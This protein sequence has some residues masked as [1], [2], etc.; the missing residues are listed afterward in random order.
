MPEPD[1][2]RRL[3]RRA[4]V[5]GALAFAAGCSQTKGHAAGGPSSSTTAP[6]LVLPGGDSGPSASASAPATPIASVG[7]V[8][9][10]IT[11]RSKP[12]LTSLF[13]AKG[14]AD[15]VIDA[16]VSRRIE[17]GNGKGDAPLNGETALRK[18]LADGVKPDVWVFA[19]GTNDVG[20]VD[21][22]AYSALIETMLAMPPP[23]TPVV[24]VDVY[25]PSNL[26]QTK[27]F[28]TVLRQIAAKRPLASVVSWYDVASDKSKKLL[29]SDN[30]H[31]NEA[32]QAAFAALVGG[33]I[34]A[35]S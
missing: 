23:T 10:S 31:P 6:T 1:R 34:A 12:A 18:L 8:G 24:W 19:L 25:R 33:A 7:M 17:V 14:I 9:D 4:F 26:P 2:T 11:V 21:H 5:L 27:M 3:P 32:G 35:L 13:K 28:N 15:V 30:L 22:D 16:E 20:N 29:S